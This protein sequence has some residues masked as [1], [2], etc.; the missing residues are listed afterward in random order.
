ME[1]IVKVRKARTVKTV[2]VSKDTVGALRQWVTISMGC[3]IPLFSLA[4]SHL[5]GTLLQD[6]NYILGL[7]F[8]GLCATC[9]SVSLSHLAWAIRDITGSSAWQAWALAIIVDMGIILCELMSV[10]DSPSWVKTAVMISVTMF[11]MVLN[12]WAFLGHGKS[13]KR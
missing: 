1:S 2:K 13:K 6:S 4:C 8:L 3:G 9:L 10:C 12:C 11:S 7:S 5:G